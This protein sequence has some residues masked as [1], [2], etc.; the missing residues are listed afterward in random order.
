V[1]RTPQGFKLFSQ[2]LPV[3]AVSAAL[4]LLLRDQQRLGLLA[5]TAER[6]REER[7]KI[8]SVAALEVGGLERR[9]EH[10][11]CDQLGKRL[12]QASEVLLRAVDG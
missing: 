7:L 3:R 10:W 4:F 11:F 2:R 1:D 5:G 8:A 9:Q 12:A 6:S